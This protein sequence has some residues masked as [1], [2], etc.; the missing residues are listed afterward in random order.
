MTERTITF[1]NEI[2]RTL[3]E[4]E[5]TSQFSDG[6][7]EETPG[8][9]QWCYAKTAVG[10]NPG[11][12]WYVEPWYDDDDPDDD[13]TVTYY[14]LFELYYLENRMLEYARQVQPEITVYD[15]WDQLQRIMDIMRT[16][17]G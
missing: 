8:W 14:D 3:W 10:P 4:N 7:W 13:G 5:L 6:L 17:N 12:N 2:Q 1:D 9:E 11:V 16:F 15:L